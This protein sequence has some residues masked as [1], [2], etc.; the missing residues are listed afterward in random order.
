MTVT[1]SSFRI[2]CIKSIII[3]I[4]IKDRF[5]EGHGVR[6]PGYSCLLF[7]VPIQLIQFLF[8]LQLFDIKIM[9][10][11]NLVRTRIKLITYSQKSYT[12][13]QFCQF[14]LENSLRV[15]QENISDELY[16]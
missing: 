15:H 2:S 4:C 8:G 11:C 5:I 13:V 14:T 10:Y 16:S 7:N 12:I 9:H 6:W 1:R 3:T